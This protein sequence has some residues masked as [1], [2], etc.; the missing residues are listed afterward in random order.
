MDGDESVIVIGTKRLGAISSEPPPGHSKPGYKSLQ[1]TEM[2]PQ[3]QNAIR[4][5]HYCTCAI[6]DKIRL[7]K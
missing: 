2:S 6:S 7:K 1:I 5:S 4:C 3:S